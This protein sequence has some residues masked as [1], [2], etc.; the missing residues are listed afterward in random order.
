MQTTPRVLSKDEVIAL[1]HAIDQ[2]ISERPEFR[3]S[4]DEV[5]RVLIRAFEEKSLRAAFR[6][7]D[8]RYHAE[9]SGFMDG[10]DYAVEWALDYCADTEALQTPLKI[11]NG[12]KL[13]Q[14]ALAFTEILKIMRKLRRAEQKVSL[15]DGVYCV[16]DSLTP[17]DLERHLCDSFVKNRNSPTTTRPDE[18]RV[19][20]SPKPVLEA[21]QPYLREHRIYYVVPK[22]L[23]NKII[24]NTKSWLV[25]VWKFDDADNLGGYTAG[26]FRILWTCLYALS[27]IHHTC[28]VRLYGDVL[29]TTGSEPRIDNLTLCKK[30]NEWIRELSERSGL[31]REVISAILED[32][33]CVPAL[34][35]ATEKDKR[36][37]ILSTPFFN[38]GDNQLSL[39]HTLIL[40]VNVGRALSNLLNGK[41]RQSIYSK[42]QAEMANAQKQRLLDIL[43]DTS[44]QAYTKTKELNISIGSEQ[45]DLDLLLWS[46]QE[47]LIVG[48][49]L[50]AFKDPHRPKEHATV[51]QALRDGVRQGK[52]TK[53]WMSVNIKRLAELTE[54][55]ETILQTYERDALVVSETLLALHVV[56]DAEVP[57]VNEA[58]IEA[59]I[60]KRT[61]TPLGDLMKVA[62]NQSYLPKE[63]KHFKSYPDEINASIGPFK[64]KR[65]TFAHDVLQ[66]WNPT[67]D[68]LI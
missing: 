8:L 44:I 50:K 22:D 3:H 54:I 5:V 12:H 20:L 38:I 21:C 30:K 31:K 19:G 53:R 61:S 57:T 52:L 41:K 14:A 66:K 63:T 62:R 55:D 42:L 9:I 32:I 15:I 11:T 18:K 64:F 39:C 4:R 59:V 40:K 2:W 16:D 58:I 23:V 60:R 43:K 6:L 36:F 68:V 25:E 51:H 47:K 48:C 65:A 28:C 17:A 35:A 27:Y 67:E 49:Q 10:L 56:F 24:E 1:D 45:T 34:L 37:E 26:D 29:K 7:D 13:L 33:V 46:R